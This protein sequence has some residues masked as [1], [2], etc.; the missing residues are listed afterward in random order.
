MGS[1]HVIQNS[2]YYEKFKLGLDE[3]LISKNTFY[4]LNSLSASFA[5]SIKYLTKHSGLSRKNI[6]KKCDM[7]DKQIKAWENDFSNE[8]QVLPI[9][10]LRFCIALSLPPEICDFLFEL[11]GTKLPR[12]EKGLIYT[13]IKN[14]YYSASLFEINDILESAHLEIW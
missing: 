14:R 2:V 9:N 12:S 3:T 4:L 5:H 11:K 13:A 6:A 1:N 7:S 10:L 8:I